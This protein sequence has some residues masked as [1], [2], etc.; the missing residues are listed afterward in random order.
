[1]SDRTEQKKLLEQIM[2]DDRIELI[3]RLAPG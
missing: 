2:R 3:K 1:M